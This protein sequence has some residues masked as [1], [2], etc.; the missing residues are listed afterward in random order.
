M[1][2]DEILRWLREEDETRLNELW[3]WADTVRKE[4]VGEEVHLRGLIEISNHCIRQCGYCGLRS[5]HK[6]LERYRM[7]E[8]EIMACVGEAERYGYGTVVLQSGED[9]GIETKWFANILRRIKRETPL[10]ITLSLGERPDEDL[11]EWRKAGADRYL[12]RFE[13]SDIG[14]YHLIHPSLPQNKSDR[15]AILQTL[16]QLGYETG[17]GVMIG[18]PGQ[19]YASLADDIELF[20]RLDLDMIGVGPYL[21]HPQTPLGQGEWTWRIPEEEQVPNTEK[22]TYKVIALTRIVCPE[23]NIPST[24]ALATLNPEWG[25]ELGLIRGANVVMPNLTPIQYRLNYE[26]Y[27]SKACLK[28]NPKDVDDSLKRHIPS[29][30]RRI[31]EGRGDRIHR[32]EGK[33]SH[34]VTDHKLLDLIEKNKNYKF[35]GSKIPK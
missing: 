26:I 10:A 3:Q 32:S 27:P 23:S 35:W 21:P 2:R 9:D 5:A 14:L 16:K 8:E 4:T 24:T 22:M 18:I 7:S 30:G 15:I 34:P 33:S 19:T 20:R 6:E 11:E 1:K 17:S 25:R 28:E 13:T 29:L 12:L 31:G